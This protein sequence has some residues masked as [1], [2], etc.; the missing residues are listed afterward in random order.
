MSTDSKNIRIN[1]VLIDSI[2]RLSK[3][4]SPK[5]Q[6]KSSPDLF[7]DLFSKGG[8]GYFGTFVGST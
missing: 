2:K 1:Y 8:D 4:R 5:Y 6:M 7:S 3:M